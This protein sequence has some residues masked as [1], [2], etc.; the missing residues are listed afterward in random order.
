[1][2]IRGFEKDGYDVSVLH[3]GVTPGER[4]TRMQDFR[5]N[6]TTVTHAHM[7]IHTHTYVHTHTRSYVYVLRHT[8][9]HT[10]THTLAHAYTHIQVLI[11]TDVFARGID[12]T[13]INM[14]RNIPRIRL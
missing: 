9:A 8:R 6:K 5:D 12:V 14:V 7:H 1:M 3:G 2:H 10:Y 11:A 13:T 4:T